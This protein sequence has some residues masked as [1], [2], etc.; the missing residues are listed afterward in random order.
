MTSPSSPESAPVAPLDCYLTAKP[1]EP[2]FTLQGGDPLASPLVK[3]WASLARVQAGAIRGDADWI[4]PC[5][6][7]ACH[8]DNALDERESNA[9]LV[10]A[11]A[12]E[13]V[14][15]DMDSYRKGHVSAG[16]D[17]GQNPHGENSLDEKARL[18]L[19]D[20]RVRYA[21][22]LSSF[23]SELDDIYET[24][25]ARGFI[26]PQGELDSLFFGSIATL[27]HMNKL[28]EPRRL[29]KQS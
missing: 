8:P 15:W 11:T 25:I 26:D 20:L 12:A 10:R 6:E 4:Y 13:E 28:V 18:D 22:K 17:A 14:G 16:E 24:L 29:M 19:H 5:L 3:L 27:K 7:A 1:D 9:L 2:V 21:Q 23:A